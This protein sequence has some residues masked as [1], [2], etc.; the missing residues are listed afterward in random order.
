MMK[1]MMILCLGLI[2]LLSFTLLL[3]AQEAKQKKEKKYA[4]EISL[5]AAAINPK[6]LFYRADGIDELVSQYA[7]FYGLDTTFTGEF[8]QNKRM[9]PVNF[10]V[11]YSLKKKWYLRAGVE[12]AFSNSSSGKEYQLDWEGVT[13][14]HEYALSYKISY[15]MPQVGMGIRLTN[16]FDLYGSV[17]LSFSRFTYSED[18]DTRLD[19]VNEIATHTIYKARGTAPGFL[20][21]LK[22]RV[23]LKK[24]Y[25]HV[26]LEYLLL[27]VNRFKGSKSFQSG[28]AAGGDVQDG[29]FYQFEWN[30]YLMEEFDYW[31]AFETEPSPTDRQ[32]I[33]KLGLD[34]SCIRLMIGFSF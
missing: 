28:G 23:K 13:E 21:G 34:L 27:K 14:N 24:I 6:Q 7:D 5:G 9:I 1:R 22:Y 26:K 3:T 15:L 16:A 18:V 30:P 29:T 10:S 12:Y 17:G 8:K 2:I 4:I 32:N 31:D 11:S 19:Q 20:M 25:A 33:D